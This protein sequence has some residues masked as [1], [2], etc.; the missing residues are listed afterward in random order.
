MSARRTQTKVEQ[1]RE[2]TQQNNKTMRQCNERL[3][4]RNIGQFQM[5]KTQEKG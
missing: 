3:K 1:N 2:L 5:R 4:E